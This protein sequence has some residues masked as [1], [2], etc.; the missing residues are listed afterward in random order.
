MC[1]NPSGMNGHEG[2]SIRVRTDELPEEPDAGTPEESWLR[3][4]RELAVSHEYDTVDRDLEQLG[5]RVSRLPSEAGVVW[6]LSL[7]RGEQVEAWEP[8]TGGLVPPDEIARLIESAAG[9]KPLV[10]APPV[11]DEPGAVRLREM[12]AAQ[13][14]ELLA[15]DPGV[16]LGDD[17]ENLH[18]HRVA[19]R[20]IRAY[21]RAARAYLDPAWRRAVTGLLDELGEATG[22]VRDLDVLLELLR[23]E[24]TR[25]DGPD[26]AACERLLA[27]VE[28]EREAARQRLLDALR[29]EGYRVALTRLRL[30]PRMAEDAR[31]VPLDRIARKVLDDL[32]RTVD[33]LGKHP[34]ED[35]LHRLRIAL[36]RTRYAVELAAPAGKAGRRFVDDAKALQALLGEYQDAVVAEERLRE[37]A[38]GDARTAASFVAGRLVERQQA[39]RARLA[40]QL[41]AAWR[42][43]RRSGTRLG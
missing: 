32:V 9:E 6:R 7:P 13:R 31:A 41:P 14:R 18:E 22:P 4:E 10:P 21:V 38:V 33:R 1:R 30:P 27:S 23:D 15:H 8:G 24:L 39:R 26:R 3:A 40:K 17:P 43:L 12:I 11:S 16:R 36:K 29:G 19:A 42:R 28:A 37:L 35:E 20:R 34:G 5:M 25:L 2:H